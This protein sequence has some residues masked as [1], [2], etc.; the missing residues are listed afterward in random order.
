MDR[1]L[2]PAPFPTWPGVTRSVVWEHSDSPLRAGM[3]PVM[4]PVQLDRTYSMQLDEMVKARVEHENLRHLAAMARETLKR[5]SAE[6]SVP[7]DGSRLWIWSDLHFDDERIRRNAKPPLPTVRTM[8]AAARIFHL[9][10]ESRVRC[11]S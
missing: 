5:P 3:T 4:T 7:A 10:P 2:V 1:R 6:L 11:E 8:N 9:G